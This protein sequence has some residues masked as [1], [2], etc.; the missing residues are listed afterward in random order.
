MPTWS[1]RCAGIVIANTRPDSMKAKFPKVLHKI[2]T[3]PVVTMSPKSESSSSGLSSA[4]SKVS[5]NGLGCTK[6]FKSQGEYRYMHLFTPPYHIQSN[7]QPGVTRDTILDQ[8]NAH[9][10]FVALA[11]RLISTDILMRS[12]IISSHS[13]AQWRGVNIL[14]LQESESS[15]RG[16]IT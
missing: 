4:S 12:M 14:A 11:P 16:R 7:I 1:T 6:A 5:C 8:S 3:P 9:I 13:I 2:K 15:S 10:V